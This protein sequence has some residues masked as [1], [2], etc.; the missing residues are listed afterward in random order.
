VI[1]ANTLPIHD[2][3]NDQGH[4]VVTIFLN[5]LV[6]DEASIHTGMC[7]HLDFFIVVQGYNNPIL[8][9]VVVL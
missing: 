2:I 5:N 3:D 6:D 4:D 8:N 9:E 7:P 1:L